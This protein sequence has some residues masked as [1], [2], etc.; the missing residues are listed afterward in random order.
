MIL[1][2]QSQPPSTITTDHG[3]TLRVL[4]GNVAQKWCRLETNEQHILLAS[5]RFRLVPNLFCFILE[6]GGSHCQTSHSSLD[7]KKNCIGNP[8]GKGGF[9]GPNT[10]G[11]ANW[12]CIVVTK[13][14]FIGKKQ[15]KMN[16]GNNI[17]V[18]F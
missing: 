7:T 16:C 10:V 2:T 3:I 12:R 11:R 6:T 4:S 14:W 9:G 13:D 8:W 15:H 1:T 5:R 18:D 17:S